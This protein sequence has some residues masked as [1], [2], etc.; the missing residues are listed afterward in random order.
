MQDALRRRRMVRNFEDRP[1]AR[2]LLATVVDAGRRAPSAGWTQGAEFIVLAEPSQVELFWETTTTPD[3]RR[4]NRSHAGARRAPAVVLPLAHAQAYTSRYSEPDKAGSG[5]ETEGAWPVPYWY[6]DCA[7]AVMAVLLAATD[8]GL[9]ALFM[10][11][12]RGEEEL[13]E[14]LGVPNGRR[15]LGAVILGWPAPDEPS[16]S[17]ARGRR[18]VTEVVHW[19]RYGGH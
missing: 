2:D 19:G 18:P 11:V 10:G 6:V 14:R 15:L 8:A 7:F 1:V 9:G 12:W 17:L 4:D 13:L 5:L 3:W 16:P